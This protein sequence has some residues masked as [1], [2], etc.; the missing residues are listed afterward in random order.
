MHT[1]GYDGSQLPPGGCVGTLVAVGIVVMV[2]CGVAVCIAVFVGWGVPVGIGVAVGG[3]GVAVGRSG[4]ATNGRY[5]CGVKPP[6]ATASPATISM[7]SSSAKP[8]ENFLCITD[9]SPTL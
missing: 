4:R 8:I 9:Y 2:G 7:D 3:T 5:D 1:V 6:C